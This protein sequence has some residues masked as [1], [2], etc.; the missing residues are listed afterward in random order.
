VSYRQLQYWASR[1]YLRPRQQTGQGSGHEFD[2]S[3]EEVA[4]AQL[5]GQLVGHGFT[6]RLAARV[7]R[8]QVSG[9]LGTVLELPDG[10]YVMVKVEPVG[11][12]TSRKEPTDVHR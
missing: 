3:A 9:G 2:W 1:G 12:L 5:M 7:A 4:T 8:A 11:W 10:M 6:P